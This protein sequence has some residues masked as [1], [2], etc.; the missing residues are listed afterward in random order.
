MTTRV[1]A[2]SGRSMRKPAVV[3]SFVFF[4]F[5]SRRHRRLCL[6]TVAFSVSVA[7][8]TWRADL[9]E[10]SLVDACDQVQ[11]WYL[12]TVLESNA[13]RVLVRYHGWFLQLLSLMSRNAPTL[14][15]L[16]GWSWKYNEWIHR[17]SLRLA[18]PGRYSFDA[19]LPVTTT[20]DPELD[21]PF[22]PGE[23]RE[24][25]RSAMTLAESIET[26]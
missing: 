25:V 19:G 18:A 3:E 24:N 23:A 7:H 12:C 11:K 4:P 8:E 2:G 5:S 17:Y 26:T 21:L 6:L 14:A 16:A 9:K 13:D 22:A 10:G 15:V 20:V 1:Y